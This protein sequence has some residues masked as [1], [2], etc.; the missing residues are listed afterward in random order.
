MYDLYLG[1]MLLPVTPEKISMSIKNKNQTIALIGSGEINI[2]KD[3][4]LTE[5]SFEALIPQAR[6]PFARYEGG[7]F[8][9]AAEYLAYF[10][11]LKT[12]KEPFSFILSRFM[13]DGKKLFST[14]INVSMEEYSITEEAR[15]GFDLNVNIR[16]KQWRPY[17]TKTIEIGTEIPAA[18]VVIE[19]ERPVVKNPSTSSSGSKKKK[20]EATEKST[21]AAA[22]QKATEKT[23]SKIKAVEEVLA[24]VGRAQT[25]TGKSAGGTKVQLM[26]TR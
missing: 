23:G 2:L 13:P 1:R 11:Q 19:E 20:Q 22:V 6:Y 21:Y 5:I 4:G 10:E 3:A 25:G 16:L 8:R 15:N 14:S 18:P 7:G 9:P 24:K 12:A 26:L 17:G